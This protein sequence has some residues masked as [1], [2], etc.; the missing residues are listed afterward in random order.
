MTAKFLALAFCLVD[1]G[2]V[3]ANGWWGGEF[4][5]KTKIHHPSIHGGWWSHWVGPSK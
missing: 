1:L 4:G 5:Y 3:S 2:I